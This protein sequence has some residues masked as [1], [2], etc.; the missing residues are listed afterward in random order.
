MLESAQRSVF[1]HYAVTN[2]EKPSFDIKKQYINKFQYYIS[3]EDTTE[4]AT[5]R[6]SQTPK[7]EKID[8]QG[9]IKTVFWIAI[10]VSLALLI[11]HFC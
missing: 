1:R 3:P 5:Q 4:N 6:T 9:M 11:G 10:S 8:T 2:G 7:Y